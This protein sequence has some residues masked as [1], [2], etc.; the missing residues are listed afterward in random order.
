[1]QYRSLEYLG[2][3]QHQLVTLTQLKTEYS[4]KEIHTMRKKGVVVEVAPEV[5]RIVGA[6]ETYE[7]RLHAALLDAGHGHVSHFAAARLWN[8]FNTNKLEITVPHNGNAR[9][10]GVEVHRSRCMERTRVIDHIPVSNPAR[11]LTDIAQWLSSSALDMV[12]QRM[13]NQ[14]LATFTAIRNELELLR[15]P[16]RKGIKIVERALDAFDP[17]DKRTT[18]DFE[19]VVAAELRRRGLAEPSRQFHVIVEGIDRYF[20][21]AYPEI[22]LAIE[23]DS[24]GYHTRLLDFDNDRAR[25]SGIS[26]LGWTL[27]SVT[28]RNFASDIDRIERLLRTAISA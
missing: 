20:D 23:V 28:R 21:F 4:D 1:M 7:Q 5:V 6:P 13:V 22:R 12:L 17:R 15:T 11:T 25:N 3:K 19:R 8:M 18:S 2:S 16:A 24:R 27:C 10:K 9:V 14:H 26:A